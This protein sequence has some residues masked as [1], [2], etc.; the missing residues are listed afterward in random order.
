NCRFNLFIANKVLSRVGRKPVTLNGHEAARGEINMMPR[1]LLFSFL[2][3]LLSGA[4]WEAAEAQNNDR[5]AGYYYPP[6]SEDPEVYSARA[7]TMLDASRATRIGFVTAI[8]T[9]NRKLPYAP[10]AVMFAKGSEAQKLIIVAL[11]DGRIDTLYRARALFADLT[12]QSRIL[13]LFKELG[14][15]DYFTFFDLLKMLGFEQLTISNGRD[16]T[17]QVLIR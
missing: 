6:P 13:P 3:L 4:Q 17:H 11:E 9:E 14:V 7:Q 16:F 5:H 1:F 10:P 8:S 12:A 15:Q 2:V